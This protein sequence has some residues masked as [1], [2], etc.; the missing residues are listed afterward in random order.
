MSSAKFGPNGDA[1][2]E[3]FEFLGTLDSAAWTR[4]VRRIK[5]GRSE[6][7]AVLGDFRR[8]GISGALYNALNSA[9]TKLVFS[10]PGFTNAEKS[11]V[12]ADAARIAT[13]LAA[14]AVA[15]PSKFSPRAREVIAQQ[16]QPAGI[17]LLALFERGLA[18][19][20]S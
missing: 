6:D 15:A 9:A 16:F 19:E 7:E 14:V 11:S 1:V 12:E 2:A 10:Q 18:G 13:R 20:E 17:D 3:F 5:D 4:V 8:P